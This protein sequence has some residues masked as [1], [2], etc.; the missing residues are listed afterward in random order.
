MSLKREVRSVQVL[1]PIV[2]WIAPAKNTEWIN[3][4]YYNQQR[5]INYTDA[6]L[7]ALG[8]QLWATSKMTWQNRQALDWILAEKGG[9]CVMFGEQCCT[10]IPNNTAP[11]GSFTQ[12]MNKLKRSRQ[13]VKGNA[14]RDAHTWDWL[15]SSLRQWRAILTKVGVV[16][17]IVLVVVALIACCVVPLLE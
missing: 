10:F 4:I 2:P 13:E 6:A 15:E 3:D 7:T 8:E 17:G 11:Y 12:S 9:V 5:F 16:I 1:N 14:G